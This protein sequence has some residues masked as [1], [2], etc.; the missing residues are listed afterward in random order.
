MSA[1]F[2]LTYS[3]MFDPPQELHER[4]DDAIASVRSFLSAEHPML[5]G[6]HDERA[7]Q[8]YGLKSPIDTRVLLGRFEAPDRYRNGW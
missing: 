8:Q 3:T 7:P 2:T 1:P 6:G 4:F 5:I